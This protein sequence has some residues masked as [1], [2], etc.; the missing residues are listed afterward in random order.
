ML[1]EIATAT[2]FRESSSAIVYRHWDNH[3]RTM[4]HDIQFIPKRFYSDVSHKSGDRAQ[5]VISNWCSNFWM[6]IVMLNGVLNF[7]FI[8]F[9]KHR[10][11][12]RQLKMR[13]V[14]LLSFY[15]ISIILTPCIKT[16]YSGVRCVFRFAHPLYFQ[17][18]TDHWVINSF[19]SLLPIKFYFSF[20]LLKVKSLLQKY[21]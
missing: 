9:G 20:S 21:V 10:L 8:N 12:F 5:C 13:R 16:V 15:F 3:F 14:L 11:Y 18:N 6:L 17:T 19:V 1:K 7:F 2:S 4:W